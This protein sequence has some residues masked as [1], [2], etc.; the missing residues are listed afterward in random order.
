M[1]CRESSGVDSWIVTSGWACS[2]CK[3]NTVYK[4]IARVDNIK[5][6]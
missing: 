3:E 4:A 1:S 6:C 5:G 2:C